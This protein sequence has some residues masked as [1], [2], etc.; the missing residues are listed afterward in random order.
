MGG[1]WRRK[2]VVVVIRGLKT[3][4]FLITMAL[5]FLLFSAPVLLALAD[6]L[7]PSALLLS[8]SPQALSLISPHLTNY[9]FRISLFDIPLLSL[10]RSTVILCVYGVCDGPRLSGG[11]YLGIATACS[12]SSLAFVS[13]KAASFVFSSGGCRSFPI[14]AIEAALFACS[15]ALG[16]GHVV[17][18]YRTSCRERRK[19]L[20]YKIDIEAVSMYHKFLQEGRPRLEQHNQS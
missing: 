16:V 13:L 2:R 12:A 9:D 10:L 20:V 11:L 7:L 15:L 14:P 4:L 19:L 3:L 1:S 6:A 5:S 17:V 8:L 18:A